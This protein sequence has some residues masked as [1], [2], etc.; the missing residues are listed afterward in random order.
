MG[1][2]IQVG[3]HAG[4]CFAEKRG[5]HGAQR[6]YVPLQAE[7]SHH[8]HYGVGGPGQKPQSNDGRHN[9]G[10]LLLRFGLVLVRLNA[11]RRE[12]HFEDI[13]VGVYNGG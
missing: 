13:E 9:E 1:G 10:Q 6:G 8:G 2:R 12:D 5:N 3:I 4:G 11:T 7:D